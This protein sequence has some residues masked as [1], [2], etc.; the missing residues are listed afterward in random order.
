MARERA[1]WASVFKEL[2]LAHS[3]TTANFVFYDA[4]RPQKVVAA[5][6]RQRGIDIGRGFP[7]LDQWTRISIGLPEGNA[8]AQQ[9]L[10]EI[11]A[12]G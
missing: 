11:L 4:G 8:K 9:A 12:K 6:F 10:R 2:K 5:A 1:Q 7:P 3:D